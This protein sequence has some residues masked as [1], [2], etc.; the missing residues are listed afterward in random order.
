[1]DQP[2][3]G[4][5]AIQM[6]L[7]D[8]DAPCPGC[9][10]NL[11]G[12]EQ[13]TCPECGRAIELALA[14]SGRGRGYFLFVLLAAGWVL[15]AGGMNTY[16]TW[17]QVRIEAQP[18]PIAR[19]VTFNSSFTINGSSSTTVINPSAPSTFT[20]N[21]GGPANAAGSVTITSPG[22]GQPVTV[23]QNGGR[24]AI[25]NSPGTRRVLTNNI[26]PT[27]GLVWSNV[28]TNTWASL[29][30]WG[31]LGLLAVV[32]LMVAIVRRRRFDREHPPRIAIGAAIVLFALY[33]GYHAVVFAREVV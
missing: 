24:T 32:M 4:T 19:I 10:Y 31:G 6:F 11:R 20:L 17:R 8:R 15:C 21:R 29:G 26:K 33:A 2:Q 28:A 7:A 16:R 9:G 13:A 22:N 27:N 5:A 23:T 14:R 1:M 30:W 25:S 12:I 18:R 3:H